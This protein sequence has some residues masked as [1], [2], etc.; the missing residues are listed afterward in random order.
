M[1]W[2]TTSSTARHSTASTRS[3]AHAIDSAPALTQAQFEDVLA[4]IERHIHSGRPRVIHRRDYATV[5]LAGRIGPRRVSLSHCRVRDVTLENG[6]TF[7]RLRLKGD[8]YDRVALPDDVARVLWWWL[9]ELSRA[10]GRELRPGDAVFP[11]IGPH[12]LRL[13]GYEGGVQ[14]ESVVPGTFSYQI[15]NR[16]ADAGI[17][18]ARWSAHALRATAATIAHENGASLENI[19]RMLAHI[20]RQQ[21]EAYIRRHNPQSAAR[22]WVPRT[23]ATPRFDVIDGA[24]A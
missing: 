8:R 24:A 9:T 16:L 6:V 12:A 22:H 10:V 5:Y 2:T 19:Q 11:P 23:G 1:L 15:T 13:H 14:L 4:V 21:T 17:V 18:G 7:L 3:T 20:N